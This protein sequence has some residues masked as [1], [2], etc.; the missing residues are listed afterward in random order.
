LA[1][2]GGVA[3]SKSIETSLFFSSLPISSFSEAGAEGNGTGDAFRFPLQVF[4]LGSSSSRQERPRETSDIAALE[5]GFQ[6]GGGA[7][8]ILLSSRL[9]SVLVTD[10]SI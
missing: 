5:A 9:I 3:G 2:L 1:F 7:T 10:I 8:E 6:R 4:F